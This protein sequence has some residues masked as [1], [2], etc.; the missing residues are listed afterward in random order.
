MSDGLTEDE[1]RQARDKVF[2][3]A[4]T[5]AGWEACRENWMQEDAIEWLLLHSRPII[6]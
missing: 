6:V 4:A 3:V 2:G 5:D 1:V